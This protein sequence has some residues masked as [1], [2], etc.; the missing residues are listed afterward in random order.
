[1]FR[2]FNFKNKNVRSYHTLSKL[3]N[4]TLLFNQAT[5]KQMFLGLQLNYFQPSYI[6][7]GNML[8]I[9]FGSTPFLQKGLNCKLAKE[10]SQCFTDLIFRI[11]ACN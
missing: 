2:I 4:D 9:I 3:A 7:F 11:V 5:R 6:S 10:L 1:M 8:F